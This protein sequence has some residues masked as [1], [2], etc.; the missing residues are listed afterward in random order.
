MLTVFIFGVVN[1]SNIVNGELKEKM[2]A[3]IYTEDQ[4]KKGGNNVA[5]LIMK[6]L[7]RLD[8]L[9]TTPG[10]ELNVIFDNCPGQNE[11]DA[12][13]RLAL[14]LVEKKFFKLVRFAFYVGILS[15]LFISVFYLGLLLSEIT[16]SAHA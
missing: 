11:N 6:T 14:L 8:M 7:L 5:L 2:Y 1:A 15:W 13:L 10:K 12:T 9:R 3:H 16:Q 4:G